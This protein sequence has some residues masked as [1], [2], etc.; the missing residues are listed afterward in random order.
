MSVSLPKINII[1]KRLKK[2]IRRFDYAKTEKTLMDSLDKINVIL[3]KYSTKVFKFTSK[4]RK[5]LDLIYHTY[6]VRSPMRWKSLLET[7]FNKN[8]L[9]KN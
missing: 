8:R 7:R 1:Y 3:N 2:Q 5:T 4:E 6:K 9:M